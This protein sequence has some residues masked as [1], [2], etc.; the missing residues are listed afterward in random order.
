MKTMEDLKQLASTKKTPLDKIAVVINEL[1]KLLIT[2]NK[3]YKSSAIS[4]PLLVKNVSATD[5]ILIRIG[6]KFSRLQGIIN[7][8]NCE[9]L[10]ESFDDTLFDIAGYIILYFA[11]AVENNES[12]NE[13]TE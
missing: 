3:N 11:F 1:Q 5:G 9:L 12:K 6:D 7:N 4:K 2:K 13:E 10:S 8:N